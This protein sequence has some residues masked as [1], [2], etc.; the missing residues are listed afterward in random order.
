M[1]LIKMISDLSFCVGRLE[2]YHQGMIMTNQKLE[3]MDLLTHVAAVIKGNVDVLED[4][5]KKEFSEGDK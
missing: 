3:G 5:F 4:W 2:G 1:R